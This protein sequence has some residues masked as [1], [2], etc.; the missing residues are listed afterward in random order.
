MSAVLTIS[1]TEP[2]PLSQDSCRTGLEWNTNS[3]PSRLGEPEPFRKPHRRCG[4]H[5]RRTY[6]SGSVPSAGMPWLSCVPISPLTSSALI[7]V[8]SRSVGRHARLHP[9]APTTTPRRLGGSRV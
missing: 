4:S 1:R 5:W 2:S 9:W 6:G 8:F 3:A 7:K